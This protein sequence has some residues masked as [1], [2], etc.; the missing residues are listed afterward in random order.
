MKITSSAFD[1][2]ELIPATHTCD[3]ENTNPPLEIHDIPEGTKSLALIVDDPDAPGGTF[4]HWIMWNVSPD[5]KVIAE[6]DWLDGSEQGVNDGGELGYMGPCPP[7]GV[8]HYHFKLY[9]L[10]KRLELIGEID[11][12]QLE[13]EIEESLLEKAEIVGLYKLNS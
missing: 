3:A 8:H 11:K 9:A 4:T 12:N 1:D 6:N 2:G 7:E 10:D 13:K 5:T